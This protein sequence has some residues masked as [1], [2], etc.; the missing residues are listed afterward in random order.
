[1]DNTV[2]LLFLATLILLGISTT[3]HLISLRSLNGKVALPEE[4]LARQAR[5]RGKIFTL[6]MAV[7]ALLSATGLILNFA[8]KK[9]ALKEALGCL[10]TVALLVSIL[11]PYYVQ[12][13]RALEAIV[14]SARPDLYSK[15]RAPQR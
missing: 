4:F 8:D 6:M 3:L 12:R 13:V 9:S 11:L 14:R 1:M 7:A 15:I 2:I 5:P 10:T